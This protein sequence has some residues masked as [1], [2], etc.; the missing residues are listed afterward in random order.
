MLRFD[1]FQNGEPAKDIDLS[2][3]YLFGQDGIPLRADLAAAHG[4]ISCIKRVPGASGLALLWLAGQA[5]RF[6]LPTCRLPEREEPYNLN[7]ELARAQMMRI[8]QKREDWGL[9]DY[10]DAAALNKECDTVRAKFTEALKAADDPAAAAALGDEALTAGLNL[11]EQI[12][13][14]HAEIFI[15]R[16]RAVGGAALRTTFGCTAV[17]DDINEPSQE[18]LRETFDFI[19]VPTPWKHIEPKERLYEHSHIDAWVTWA[20]KHRKLVHAGPLLSFEPAQIPDWMYLWEHDYEA[21]R[22]MVYEHVQRTVKRYERAVHYWKVVSGVHAFNNFNLTF[23]QLM[24]LTRMTCQL[25]KKIAPRSQAVIELVMPW[26]EYY[27]RNQ[28]SIPPLLYADMAVQ[29]G[30]RFDAFG[31]QVCLG[32]PVDGHYVRDLMQI[33]AMLDEFLSLGKPLHVTA[34]QVPSDIAAD[35]GDAWSGEIEAHRAGQWHVPWSQRLQAEWLQGFFRVAISKPFVES[36]CWRDLSDSPGHFIPHGGL[37]TAN[38]EPKLAYKELR[39]F[40]AWLLAHRGTA[41]NQ[42]QRPAE[43]SPP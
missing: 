19:A 17:L 35:A 18:R 39:N 26:S 28:K 11:G 27:A 9:F 8:A 40:K 4:Q 32:A 36:V 16:R 3:A 1:A 14:Y 10:A 43:P 33:S 21:L 23:E 37:C 22:D 41:V 12:A 6:L 42:Q 13:L 15:N 38:L 24:E 2:G 25:V 5:G 29:S 30:I 31:V 7:V 20:G 34:C